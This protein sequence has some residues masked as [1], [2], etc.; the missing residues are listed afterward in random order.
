MFKPKRVLALL[1]V[2]VLL[3]ALSYWIDNDPQTDT[4]LQMAAVAAIDF[5]VV[6]ILYC[7]AFGL[8][9]ERRKRASRKV[10]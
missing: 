3:T 6:T 1:T 9:K 2:S 4:F 5:L 7:C 8:L 10:A